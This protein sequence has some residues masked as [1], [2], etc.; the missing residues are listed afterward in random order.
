MAEPSLTSRQNGATSVEFNDLVQ[1]IESLRTR[2]SKLSE[3]SLRVSESLDANTV[4]QEVIDNARDLTDA[5]YGALL[6]YE[7][8]GEIQDFVT[9]GLSAEEIRRLSVLPKGLGLLGHMN[10]IRE[11]LRLADIS[12]HPSSVGF[13][14]NHPPMKTFLG[15]PIRHRG[16][17]V[18]NIYLTEKEGGREFT[19]EDRNVLVMFA[20]QAGA[21]IFNARRYRQEQQAKAD[22]EALVNISPVGVLVF[23]AKTGDLVSANDETRR[24]VG[25]LHAPGRS[26]GQLLEVMSLRRP[27]GSD[28]PV[29]QLPTTKALKQGET[30]LAEEVVI[31]LQDGRTITTLVNARPI[32]RDGG[33]IASVVATIQDITTLEEMKRRRAEFLNN[34]SHELRTPLMS[35]K[36]SA[37]TLLNSPDP[38]DPVETRQFLR[39]IDEQTDHM[40][41]LINDL[42][43]I[44]HIELGTLSV[45]PE[46]MEVAVLMDQVRDVYTHAEAPTSRVEIEL[47]PAVPKVMADNRRILRVLRNLVASV[48]MYSSETSTVKIR[49]LPRDGY[50]AFTVVD[51]TADPVALHS[52]NESGNGPRTVPRVL[53][54]RNG[55][56]R[57]GIAICR[58]IVEAHGGRLSAEDGIEG[59]G[60]GFTITIPMVDEAAYVV[61]LEESQYPSS[62]RSH[63]GRPRVL[64]FVA[65]PETA[66]YVRDILSHSDSFVA[67]ARDL[68][69]A[70]GMIKTGKPHAIVLEPA[71]PWSE[72]L[73]ILARICRI[74]GVPVILVAGHGWDRYIGRAFD[75]GAFDYI[76]KPFTST[77]LLARVGAAVRRRSAAGRGEHSVSYLHGD[78]AI[79]YVERAVSVAGSPVRLTATEYRLLVELSAA[80][81]RVLTH[82]QLLTGVWGPL[83]SSDARL[84][85]TYVKELR[86]K[87]GDDAARPTYIFTK[88]GVGYL[89]PKPAKGS[90]LQREAS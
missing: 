88:P 29:D 77:E 5:R 4:L 51:E 70:E 57:L 15:M 55:S 35:I 82:E 38:V 30:V 34:V 56:D 1:K 49:V 47:P 60:S 65:D 16:E 10:E 54:M 72:G 26:L 28:I 42:V 78:L 23:D 43:D 64:G 27:D 79:D 46:P 48:S 20:S 73:E 33:D 68:D 37:S 31:H 84:V 44:T 52:A 58:G 81:G 25:K 75:L 18:G 12:S 66:R 17:H 21:A 19:S 32:R 85:R 61:G 45:S 83:Y 67:M 3:A 40:R 9:S 11:P 7:Q 87:L 8:S 69:E 13:P 24:I 76:A 59:R 86:R 39:V 62:R 80:A 41:D 22:L 50:V 36:G 63:E 71:L 53:G 89:M 90:R 6:T 2:L 14:E 74:S